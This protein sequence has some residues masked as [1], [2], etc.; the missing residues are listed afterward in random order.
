VKP[1]RCVKLIRCVKPGDRGK[2]AGEEE[3]VAIS[4]QFDLDAPAE[5]VFGVLTDPDRTTR[6]LPRGMKTETRDVGHVRVRSGSEVYEYEVDV[7]PDRLQVGWRS[8]DDAGLHGTARVRDAPAGGSVVD[9]EVTVPGGDAERRRAQD[10]VAEALRHLQ[11]D[12]SDNFN[13]G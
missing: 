12:V 3:P 11:R 5:V 1:I 8:V 4:D 2:Q 7:V 9:V 10:L 13:A 6:W